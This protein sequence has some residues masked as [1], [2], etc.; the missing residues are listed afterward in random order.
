MSLERPIPPDPYSMLPV[1]PPFALTSVD[2]KEGSDL[3]KSADFSADN[4]SPELSWHD[5]PAGTKS[6]MVTCFDP[7]APTPSGFWH[8]VAVGI[9]GNATSLHANAGAEGGEELPAGAFHL[10]ND[11]GYAGFG[12]AA[13]PAGDRPHRYVFAVTALD[14]TVEEIGITADF[15]PAKAHFFALTHVVGRAVLTGTYAIPA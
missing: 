1:V 10:N 5:A 13:P 7:D 3:P 8:W 11:Y 12:G 6:F 4:L 14:A 9:P 15:T 2:F